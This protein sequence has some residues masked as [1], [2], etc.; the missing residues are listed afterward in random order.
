MKRMTMTV[1]QEDFKSLARELTYKGWTENRSKDATQKILI[2]MRRWCGE[3]SGFQ[4]FYVTT[5]YHA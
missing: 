4:K 2:Y 3:W 1:S 5:F